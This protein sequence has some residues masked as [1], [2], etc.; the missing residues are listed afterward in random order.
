[1]PGELQEGLTD[2]TTAMTDSHHQDVEVAETG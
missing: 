1:M 2:I